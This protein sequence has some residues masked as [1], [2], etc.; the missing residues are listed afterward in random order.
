MGGSFREDL[1][2]VAETFERQW[3]YEFFGILRFA[4]D[5][6]KNQ[7]RQEQ[8]TNSKNGKSLDRVGGELSVG[9]G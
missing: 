3:S 4:Q 7:Q 6:S 1:E 2:C 5:D 9:A 8:K